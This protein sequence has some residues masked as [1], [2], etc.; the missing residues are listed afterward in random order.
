MPL[1]RIVV[2]IGAFAK[3]LL[4]PVVGVRHQDVEKVVADL[5]GDKFHGY[6]PPTVSS[7]LR[8]LMPADERCDW[9]VVGSVDDVVVADDLATAVERYGFEFMRAAGD[10][11]GLIAALRVGHGHGHQ[12]AYRLPVALRL[13]RGFEEEAG[14]VERELESLSDRSDPAAEE[15]RR[16]AERLRVTALG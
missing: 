15:F 4:N 16:F 13:A 6:L 7:P 9:V 11:A 12:N 10:L 14:T 2:G 1:N 5:R 8:Y 3:V